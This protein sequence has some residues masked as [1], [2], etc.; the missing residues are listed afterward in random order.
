MWFI[1]FWG[2]THPWDS[3]STSGEKE[4]Q[5]SPVPALMTTPQVARSQDNTIVV[6]GVA[7]RSP[8]GSTLIIP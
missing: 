3:G 2:G 5:S 1:R 6:S 8:L 7:K 4:L